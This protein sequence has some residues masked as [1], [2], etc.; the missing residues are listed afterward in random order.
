MAISFP[1][2]EAATRQ[3]VKREAA[4]TQRPSLVAQVTSMLKRGF[5]RVCSAIFDSDGD[6]MRF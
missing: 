4:E 6:C 2:P 3:R 5:E 1:A